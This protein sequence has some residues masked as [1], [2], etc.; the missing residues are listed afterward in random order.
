M[1][2]STGQIFKTGTQQIMTKQAR[3]A[4]LS[5]QLAQQA[6]IANASDDS[7]AFSQIQI[8][9]NQYNKAQIYQSNNQSTASA[10]N[11]QDSVLSSIGGIVQ[12]L[13]IVANQAGNGTLSSADRLALA[14]QAQSLLDA[15]QN[16]ANSTDLNGNYMFSG[17]KANLAPIGRTYD[18]STNSYDYVYNGDDKQRFQAISDSTTV[19]SNDP[20]SDIFFNIASGNGNF[21]VAQTA[22]PNQGTVVASLG[23][24]PD[25]SQY[26][27]GDYTLTINGNVVDVTD[28]NNNSVLSTPYQDGGSI[29]FNG[30]SLSLSGSAQ[31]GQTFSINSGQKVS[32]FS[33]TQQLIT[34]LKAPNENQADRAAIQTTNYQI[35]SQ[36][37]RG[38]SSVNNARANVGGRLNQ[39]EAINTSTASL[40]LINQETSQKLSGSDTEGLTSIISDF[41][42]SQAF[43]QIAQQAFT[44][45]SKLSVFNFI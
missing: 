28:S 6:K 29:T 27:P 35:I 37:S 40:M 21:Y 20:G 17:S 25:S 36:L 1:R 39:L 30:I 5:K 43:L 14:T 38:L 26:I 33:M 31:D 4:E 23:S 24:V 18:S 41:Q 10:L 8:L 45:I 44:S 7:V 19:A 42:S 3:L 11:N 2:I 9:N 22:N 32:L 12:S 15:L 16:N 34:S 13:Q